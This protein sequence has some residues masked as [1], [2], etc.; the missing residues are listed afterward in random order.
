VCGALF[1]G[2]SEMKYSLVAVNVSP[3]WSLSEYVTNFATYDVENEGNS[4]VI[5]EKSDDLIG[6]FVVLDNGKKYWLHRPDESGFIVRKTLA[7]DE[8]ELDP[9]IKSWG[10]WSGIPNGGTSDDTLF[11]WIVNYIVNHSV[12]G[13]TDPN[14]FDWDRRLRAFSPIRSKVSPGKISIYRDLGMR[15]QDRHTMMKPGRA[16]TAM[17]P[18]VE[19]KQVIM[20]VDS[21]LNMFCKRELTLCVSKERKDFHLAY[22]GDQAPMENI[23][24]TW[25]R[26]SSASSCMRYDFAHLKCH[27]AEAY[28]S[29]DFEVI[30]VFDSDMRVAAR[31]VVYVAHHSGVPQAGPIYGVSEQALDTVHD[32]LIVRDAEL[33]NPDWVGA[34]LLALPEDEYEDPPSNFVGPYLDVE[35]RTLDLTC[36]NKY[37]IQDHGGEIDASNYQGIISAGGTQCTCCGDNVSEADECYSEYYEG[38]CCEDCYNENHFYCEYAEESYH[39]N[40]QRTAY[41]IDS[42]GKREELTVSSWACEDGDMFVRCSDRKYWHMEDVEYCEDED[43]WISPDSIE[44]YF[45]SDWDGELYNNDKLC[46]TTDGQLVAYQELKDSEGQWKTNSQGEWYEEEEEEQCIA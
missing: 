37:L 21:F 13:L 40:D 10:S 32:H 16:F 30:T 42:G 18:E 7:V 36:D 25:T 4:P 3:D 26:K 27:P 19:H 44:D 39:V 28:A 2:V 45:R 17:F 9:V 29:G 33:R 1:F 35:P 23:D 12:F 14:L 8:S 41:T 15:I 20:F 5:T 34:R 46:T 43:E 22:S 24:T 31:C 6:G 11:N 38:I